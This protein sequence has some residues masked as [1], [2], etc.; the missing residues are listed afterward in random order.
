MITEHEYNMLKGVIPALYTPMGENLSIDFAALE[1]Q[2]NYLSEAGVH[3]FFVNGTTAE[4][5][6]LSTAE[7]RDV[8]ISVRKAAGKDKFICAA[9]IQPSTFQVIREMRELEDGKPDFFVA[10][11]PYYFKTSQQDIF[12]H[13]KTIAKDSPVPLIL[14]NI[15]QNTHNPMDLD[16]VLKLASLDNIAGIKDSSGNFPNFSRGLLTRPPGFAWIQGEDYLP[17]A[18]FLLGAQA[19]V[20]GLGNIFIEPYLAMYRALESG[21]CEGIIDGQR[22]INRLYS[23]LENWPGRSTAVIKAAGFLLGR[24]N[25][26]L[27]AGQAA[28]SEAELLILKDQLSALNI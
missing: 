12:M 5:P 8:I 16:T 7:K 28:L 22:A 11:T 17:G 26:R 20:T 3:G 21:D 1:K 25:T 18:A 15:P 27:R 14:Y 9:C 13:F 4:G 6:L 2:V 19:L 23:V 24:G 10:V